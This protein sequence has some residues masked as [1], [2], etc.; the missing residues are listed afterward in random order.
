MSMV[1][2]IA[3]DGTVWD[4]PQERSQE[5]IKAGG[6]LAMDVLSPNGERWAIRIDKVHDALKAGGQLAPPAPLDDLGKLESGMETQKFNPAEA[7]AYGVTHPRTAIDAIGRGMQSTENDLQ[8][9]FDNGMLGTAAKTV[10]DAALGAIKSGLSTGIDVYNLGAKAVN[11]IGNAIEPA[12]NEADT[13]V[14][15]KPDSL[16]STSTAQKVGGGVETMAEWLAG[17]GILNG[18]LKLTKVGKIAEASKLLQEYPRITGVLGKIGVGAAT[19][20]G[21]GALHDQDNAADAAA[22]GALWGGAGATV[23]EL[24]TIYKGVKAA[25]KPMISETAAAESIQPGLQRGIRS[26]AED[27]AGGEGVIADEAQSIR[28][29]VEKTADAVYDKSKGL[30]SKID[31]ATGNRFQPVENALKDNQR[32]MR[33]ATSEEELADLLKERKTLEAQQESIFRDAS[34]NGVDRN[35]VLQARAAY[36]KSAALYDLNKQIEMSTTGVRPE[37]QV[38]GST[39]EAVDPKKLLNRLNKMYDSGRLQ[40]ALG[41]TGAKKLIN[42]VDTAMQNKDKLINRAKIVRAIGKYAGITSGAGVL[43]GV[44]GEVIRH[45]TD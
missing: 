43:S 25:A 2:I 32:A 16:E 44:S 10:G 12:G 27:V 19:G 15:N 30:F 6:K 5:A 1:A 34:Q 39:Q 36:K 20:A 31:D 38:E 13:P 21:L 14:I 3:P 17:E 11:K 41:N 45:F 22:E 4:I 8:D 35:T 24:P 28:S 42:D 23:A 37:I 9:T 29:A 26:V 18:A 7:I 40:Q 33:S